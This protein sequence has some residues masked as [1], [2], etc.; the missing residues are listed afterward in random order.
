MF[1]FINLT[2]LSSS[3][4]FFNLLSRNYAN[5]FQYKKRSGNYVSKIKFYIYLKIYF[6]YFKFSS[7]I[8]NVLHQQKEH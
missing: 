7:K 6:N 1:K 3:K 2:K 8:V 5:N 4:T